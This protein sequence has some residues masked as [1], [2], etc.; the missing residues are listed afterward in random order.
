NPANLNLA[1]T[2]STR[3]TSHSLFLGNL[4]V[5]NTYYLYVV[6]ADEAGNVTTNNNG[7]AF[8]SFV[9]APTSDILLVDTYQDPYGFFGSP[10]LRGYTNVIK[11]LGVTYDLWTG[12]TTGIFT[13]V[14]KSYRVVIWRTSDFADDIGAPQMTALAN[15]LHGGGSLFMASMEILS[16]LAES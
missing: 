13:N 2:N 1:I 12:S 8:Y 4:V 6:S 10:P 14:L 3:T 9:A 11:Q 16:R 5:S 15:Y 7:G